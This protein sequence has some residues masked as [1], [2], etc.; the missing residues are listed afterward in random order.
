MTV[1]KPNLASALA[2]VQAKLPEIRKGETAEV[3]G[4]TKAGRPF[5][6]KYQYA[7]LADISKAILPL[8]GANGLSWITRPTFNDAGRFV[9][10]YELR[11]VSDQSITG[12]Y[13]L[14]P[15]DKATPQEL[16]SA[17]TYARRYALCSVTGVAPETDDDGHSAQRQAEREPWGWEYG[18]ALE[19]AEP[20]LLTD[21]QSKTMHT[22]MSKAGITDRDERLAFAAGIVGRDI[23]TSKELTRHEAGLVIAALEAKL[24]EGAT[25]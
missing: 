6:Y 16:G 5:K 7:D 20:A 18:S 13:P 22:L 25:P 3:E 19:P 2:A 10:A 17:I 4:I 8:L 1:E 14:P 9:L 12:E 24:A 23:T 15:P 11:H 21:K